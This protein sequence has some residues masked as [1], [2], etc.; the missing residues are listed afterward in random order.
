MSW[1]TDLAEDECTET[2]KRLQDFVFT[3]NNYGPEHIKACEELKCTYIVFGKEIGGQNHTPHLQGYVETRNGLTLR[4]IRKH[5]HEKIWVAKRR[6]TPQQ[7]ADYCKKDHEWTERGKMKEGQ[8]KRN[9]LAVIRESIKQDIPMHQI[10]D[11]CTSV[12]G[13]LAAP[14][15]KALMMKHRT[16]KPDVFWYWGSSETGKTRKAVE[17]CLERF[18]DYDKI[19]VLN[20]FLNGYEGSKAVIFDD[21]RPENIGISILLNLLDRYKCTANVKGYTMPF[22][23]ELI[24]VTS[25][26]SPKE[27]MRHYPGENPYQLER[28]IDKTVFFEPPQSKSPQ[29]RK[30]NIALSDEFTF[31]P[32]QV[33]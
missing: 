29:S 28:R 22:N 4:S 26:L 32:M 7:A 25:P 8:G 14:K 9:D 10:I 17:E 23:A 19:S 13:A 2:Q 27:F 33:S 31:Y 24:F 1:N 11:E 15:I 12:Q 30:G 21:L 3:I 18:G 6:G 16:T 20:N 5:F